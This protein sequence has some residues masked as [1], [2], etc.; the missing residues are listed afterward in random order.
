MSLSSGAISELSVAVQLIEHGWAVAFP[1]THANN[2]DLIIHKAGVSYT[3][4]IKGSEF[5][6]H[7]KTVI[8]TNWNNYADVDWIIL[9]DRI[10][11]QFYIFKKGELNNRRTLTL[12]PKKL[13]QNLNN[14][15]RI[16]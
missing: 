11:Q 2:W 13:S 1:F 6:E 12:D 9:H 5:S 8:K 7:T 3:V 14:W 10:E 4:Q 15:K 16:K